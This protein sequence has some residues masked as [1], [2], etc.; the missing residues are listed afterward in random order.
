[1]RVLF[2]LKELVKWLMC[3]KRNMVLGNLNTGIKRCE[4]LLVF[5]SWAKKN[6]CPRR[7]SRSTAIH[8][9]Y[10]CASYCLTYLTICWDLGFV[11]LQSAVCLLFTHGCFSST[12]NTV[13]LLL[14]LLLFANAYYWYLA[15]KLL[16][17]ILLWMQWLA[18]LVFLYGF[19]PL[20]SPNPGLAKRE[21]I[22]PKEFAK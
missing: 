13:K 1:M 6:W 3:C 21:D 14:L 7:W 18:L 22:V 8:P 12:K 9:H 17:I 16:L 4:R 15:M 10:L 20:K 2:W 5:E 11:C 19:L